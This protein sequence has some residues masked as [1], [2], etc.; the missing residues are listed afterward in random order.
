MERANVEERKKKGL[1]VEYI[2]R[3]LYCPE[4]GAFFTLPHDK[5]GT[6]TGTCSSCEEQGEVDDEFEILSE[7]SFVFNNVTSNVHDFFYIRPDY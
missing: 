3:S 7:T 6:S 4:K 2:F 5:L 1:L